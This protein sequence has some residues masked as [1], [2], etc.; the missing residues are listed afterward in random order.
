MP[1][2]AKRW[3]QRA[4]GADCEIKSLMQTRDDVFNQLTHITANLTGEDVQTSRDP[5]KFDRL[6]VL[7]D[8]I[9][10]RVDRLIS[11]KAETVDLISKVDDWRYREIL[12][13]RYIDMQTFERIAVDMN[14]SWRQVIRLHGGALAEA[15]KLLSEKMS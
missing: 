14:Y 1:E 10:N 6:A 7:D 5:H 9:N 13:R 4:S 8:I 15:R 11:I 12:K 2:D 3:L